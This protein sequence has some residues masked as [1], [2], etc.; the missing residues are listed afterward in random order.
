MSTFVLFG[1][2]FDISIAPYHQKL[3]INILNKG[4]A[5]SF[6]CTIICLSSL[7]IWSIS[8]V[9]NFFVIINRTAFS[10]FVHDSVFPVLRLNGLADMNIFRARHVPCQ[11]TFQKDCTTYSPP[12]VSSLFTLPHQH[13][14]I[15]FLRKWLIL[16]LKCCILL[17]ELLPVFLCLLAILFLLMTFPHIVHLSICWSDYQ[18]SLFTYIYIYNFCVVFSI[19]ILFF[20][21][22]IFKCINYIFFWLF[23]F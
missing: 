6:E 11:N 19:N 4:I 20:V 21:L 3:F 5:F 16:K 7:P 17:L 23:P 22:F 13:W 15:L 14:V 10:I 1:L 18:S 8:V 12:E 2:I 9:S